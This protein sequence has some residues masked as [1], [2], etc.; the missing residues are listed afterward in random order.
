MQENYEAPSGTHH[1]SI[2]GLCGPDVAQTM[3]L[4]VLEL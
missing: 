4:V 3:L 2:T 1:H